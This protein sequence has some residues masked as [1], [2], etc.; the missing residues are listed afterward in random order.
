M[1]S[2]ADTHSIRLVD[3]PTRNQNGEEGR[4]EA[5]DNVDVRLFYLDTGVLKSLIE[6]MHVNFELL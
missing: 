3:K 5:G 1:A 6:S 2:P 4:G